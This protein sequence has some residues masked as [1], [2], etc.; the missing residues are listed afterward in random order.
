MLID[1]T[2]CFGQLTK[3][4]GDRDRT[5]DGYTQKICKLFTYLVGKFDQGEVRNNLLVTMF[6]TKLLD[7]G[8]SNEIFTVYSAIVTRYITSNIKLSPKLEE[9]LLTNL[10]KCFYRNPRVTEIYLDDF[11]SLDD[12]L[13]TKAL[14][15][16]VVCLNEV[17]KT[18]PVL[19]K[20]IHLSK[21]LSEH[22]LQLLVETA[23]YLRKDNTL[24]LFVSNAHESKQY[25]EIIRNL[26]RAGTLQ[27]LR[28]ILQNTILD[29]GLFLEIVRT[30]SNQLGYVRFEECKLQIDKLDE[31]KLLADK[32]KTLV[33]K[34]C[35][36]QGSFDFIHRF[37]NLNAIELDNGTVGD[38][39]GFL[40]SLT[41][42]KQLT[43]LSLKHIILTSADLISMVGY[44][45]NN[46]LESLD[47][48]G[49][50]LT[51][52]DMEMISKLL[53]HLQI[54]ELVLHNIIIDQTYDMSKFLVNTKHLRKLSMASDNA[55]QIDQFMRSLGSN[56]SINSF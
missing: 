22:T 51:N 52:A 50:I 48:S 47:I 40:N 34:N 29:N 25:V 32:C 45:E 21:V 6:K 1:D 2:S 35:E 55:P 15:R 44:L 27:R 18:T 3:L 33:L 41:N 43:S 37:P 9:D 13:R 30:C 53:E 38:F 42:S 28:L 24:D 4:L 31:P 5:R 26:C 10:I 20:S 7:G 14:S 49:S 12:K 11:Q 46:I 36:L 8:L 19:Y 54:K 16:F 23:K 17:S 39:E 56:R